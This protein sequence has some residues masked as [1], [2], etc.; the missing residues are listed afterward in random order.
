MATVASLIIGVTANTAQAEAKLNGLKSSVGR[1]RSGAASMDFL[2]TLGRRFLAFEGMKQAL[3][4]VRAFTSGLADARRAGE[5]WSRSLGQAFDELTRKGGMLGEVLGI[6][7]YF[8]LPTMPGGMGPGTFFGDIGGAVAGPGR[9]A[10]AL[11][12]GQFRQVTR[13]T[14]GLGGLATSQAAKQTTLLAQIAVNTRKV[15]VS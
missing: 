2:S 6:L 4:G 7:A 5:S 11:G 14:E 1:V 8:R 15:T 3:T 10:P 12:A 13:L 9:G